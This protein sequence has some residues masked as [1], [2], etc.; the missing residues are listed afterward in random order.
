MR[1]KV[2]KPFRR[3]APPQ[4]SRCPVRNRFF[5]VTLLV[6][7]ADNRTV[8]ASVIF[9]GRRTGLLTVYVYSVQNASPVL[10]SHAQ[11]LTAHCVLRGPPKVLPRI[12]KYWWRGAEAS[13]PLLQVKIRNV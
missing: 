12:Y 3:R 2:L 10:R 8:Y 5:S 4:S 13:S 9:P 7:N 11:I 6:Y 1:V